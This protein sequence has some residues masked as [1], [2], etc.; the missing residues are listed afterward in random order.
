MNEHAVAWRSL[1]E[2]VQMLTNQRQNTLVKSPLDS[3]K[4]HLLAFS[5]RNY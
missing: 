3:Q 5:Q 2:F 4:K 1:L